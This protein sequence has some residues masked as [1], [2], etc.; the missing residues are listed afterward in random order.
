[1]TGYAVL[2]RGVNVGGNRKVAMAELRELLA[3]LG[4][5][6]VKTLLQSG[7]AVLA[8]D[9]P[10]A[11]VAARIEAALAERYGTEIRVL[12]LTRADLQ[13][14]ADAHP[15]REIADNGSRMLVLWLF[16]TPPAD[17]PSPAELDPERIVV[18]NGLIYQWCP[19]GISNSPDV[20][21]FV[22]KA[23][24]VPT[25]GRNWNTLEKLLQ[26]IPD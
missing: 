18:R 23:W 15:L 10:A 4:F 16:G 14:A 2:L 3:D 9:G 24:K 26:A 8:A 7:N 17:A 12:V 19:D 25:T 5:T 11:A 20:A 22:R 13:A 1:M 6:Q 21:A